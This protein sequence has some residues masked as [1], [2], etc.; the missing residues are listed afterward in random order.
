[1]NQQPPSACSSAVRS[2]IP[3]PLPLL[4]GALVDEL[5]GLNLSHVRIAALVLE[6]LLGP[7]ETHP[8]D[9]DNQRTRKIAEALLKT[10]VSPDSINRLIWL[11]WRNFDWELWGA[12]VAWIRDNQ[13]HASHAVIQA[14]LRKVQSGEI[15]SIASL[16]DFFLIENQPSTPSLKPSGK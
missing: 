6:L 12:I 8:Q 2:L 16:A 7:S 15:D 9:V 11:A 10:R 3:L 13:P 14:I 5:C 4:V 1:M